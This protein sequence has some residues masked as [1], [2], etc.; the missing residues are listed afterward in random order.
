MSTATDTS[1][2]EKVAKAT[3][4]P[5]RERLSQRTFA[6]ARPNMV[7]LTWLENRSQGSGF[8]QRQCACGQHTIA[9]GECDACRRKREAGFLQRTSL[10]AIPGY[11]RL[12]QRACHK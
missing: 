5:E 8:L 1:R 12:L 7:G 10:T 3:H 11:S 4:K 6:S 2:P 9:G